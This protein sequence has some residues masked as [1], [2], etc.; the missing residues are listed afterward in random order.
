LNKAETI[1][2]EM[3]LLATSLGKD[4]GYGAALLNAGGTFST[5]GHL[6]RDFLSASNQVYIVHIRRFLQEDMKLVDQERK[7]LLNRRLDMDALKSKA[8]KSPTDSAILSELGK[9]Q[10]SF[11]EQV[12]KVKSLI[13]NV[14]TKLPELQKHLKQFIQRYYE[15][16]NK[17]QDAVKDLQKKL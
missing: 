15:H 9:S 5:V 1:G 16:L 4:Q 13:K 7:T 6:E 11:D 12:N 3:T 14:E 17:C 2:Q 10:L 8:A